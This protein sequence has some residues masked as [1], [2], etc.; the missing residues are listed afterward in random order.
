MIIKNAADQAIDKD[1]GTLPN[2]SAA[3]KNWF[4]KITFTKI[5]KTI[6]NY[7]VVEVETDISF[8][9]VWQTMSPRQLIMKP[10]KQRVEDWYICHAET[11]LILNVDEIIEYQSAKYRIMNK[12]DHSKYGFVEYHILEDFQ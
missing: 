1:S 4:Q 12:I 3:M 6:V 2:V 10:E 5:V 11:S 9:G 7:K 8:Q